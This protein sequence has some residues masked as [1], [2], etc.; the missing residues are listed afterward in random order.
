MLPLFQSPLNILCE[1]SAVGK[2]GFV[3]AIACVFWSL[4]QILF[5]LVGYLIAS[6]RMIKVVSVVP[7]A[8]FFFTWNLLPESPRWLVSKGKTDEATKILT[9]ISETNNVVAPPD[10]K[11]RVEKLAAATKEVSLGYLSLFS[12]MN[13]GLRTIFCTIGFTAS[14]FIYYQMVINVGNMAGNTFLNLFLL[15]LVEG[16]GNMMGMILANKLGRR[17][18]HTGLLGLNTLILGIL[19]GVVM[20]QTDPENMYWSTPTISFL[21]M[22]VKM[23]ISAT[24]VVAYIQV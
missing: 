23:N 10:L 15:G 6:W 14:A 2:R 9:K 17:W 1:I 16:P 21:C 22:W 13:L 8:I 19:M 4:G 18:T 11:V 3:I 24:F 20:Y 12:R 7:L 5:P